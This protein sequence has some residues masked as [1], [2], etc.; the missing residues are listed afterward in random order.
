MA[1]QVQ[2]LQAR[3]EEEYGERAR[4]LIVPLKTVKPNS[5]RARLSRLHTRNPITNRRQRPSVISMN[6]L[7]PRNRSP[8]PAEQGFWTP[9]RPASARTVA[10]SIGQRSLSSPLSPTFSL[11]P[12]LPIRPRNHPTSAAPRSISSP[13]MPTVPRSDI[14]SLPLISPR[15]FRQ[16][17]HAESL[18]EY[19]EEQ[20][21]YKSY[22]SPSLRGYQDTR[23]GF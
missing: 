7:A 19:A 14:P 20:N 18:R 8:Q 12:P 11:A 4:G 22:S 16:I 10:S 6:T 13:L 9:Q 5:F 23:R 17:S 3:L 1:I 15:T 21:M 2:L